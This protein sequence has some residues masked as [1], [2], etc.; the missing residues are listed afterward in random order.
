MRAATIF[1]R[2]ENKRYTYDA[3]KPSVP[4]RWQ[5]VRSQPLAL[6]QGAEGTDLAK[7]TLPAAWTDGQA[8]VVT[9]EVVPEAGTFAYGLVESV[10][11]GSAVTEVSDG[12]TFDTETGEVRWLFFDGEPRKLSYA[13]DPAAWKGTNATFRG[14]VDFTGGDAKTVC[15]D[16]GI[17][18]GGGSPTAL[19]LRSVNF[20]GG[21]VRIVAEAPVGESY[22]LERSQ[23]LIRWE[24][25][26]LPLP[27]EVAGP[28]EFSDASEGGAWFYRVRKITE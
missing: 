6:A 26:G 25:R 23:D 12:G 14:T 22:Q 3:G 8:F 16:A 19:G 11:T 24:G 20:V 17:G 5:E 13:L 2:G 18:L 15:G 4:V 27:L 7:R 1:L 10:P 21:E 28:L 9:I